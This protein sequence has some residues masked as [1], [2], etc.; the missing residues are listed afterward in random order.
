[1]ALRLEIERLSGIDDRAVSRDGIAAGACPGCKAEPFRIATHPPERGRAGGRCV[2]CNDPVGWVYEE[3]DTLFGK[4]EDDA[5][6]VH[7]RARV[8]G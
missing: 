3:P 8:Y 6:L 7:G 5:I 2:A 4:E 1:M